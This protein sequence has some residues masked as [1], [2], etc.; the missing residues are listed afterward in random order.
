MVL[1]IWNGS[2]LIFLIDLNVHEL[3]IQS[4]VPQGS[5]LGPTFFILFI[6][7]ITHLDLKSKILLYTDDVV[8]YFSGN[9]LSTI[10]NT[11]QSDL[12]QVYFWTIQNRLSISV[13]KL[14]PS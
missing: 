2:D 11:L 10:V 1:P 7:D 3:E 6:N 4:G 14:N 5:V 13:P 8:I 9:D 12:D